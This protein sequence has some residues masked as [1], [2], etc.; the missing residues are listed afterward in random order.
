LTLHSVT[1]WQFDLQ[2][3]RRALSRSKDIRRKNINLTARM[4]SNDEEVVKPA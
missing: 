4:G 3:A 2:K 1:F